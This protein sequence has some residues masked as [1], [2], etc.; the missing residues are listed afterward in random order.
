MRAVR[1]ANPKSITTISDT[2]AGDPTPKVDTKADGA[3]LFGW[4]A[5]SGRVAVAALEHDA[6]LVCYDKQGW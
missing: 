5:S 4:T 2:F 1:L 3:A 6:A